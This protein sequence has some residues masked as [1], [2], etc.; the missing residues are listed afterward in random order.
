MTIWVGSGADR[1][2]LLD[3][4]RRAVDLDPQRI[5]QPGIRP[6]GADAGSLELRSPFPSFFDVQQDFVIGMA[7]AR[8]VSVSARG[9]ISPSFVCGNRMSVRGHRSGSLCR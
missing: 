6:A 1:G 8:Q 2:H 3:R 4:H 7:D 5:D 9:G